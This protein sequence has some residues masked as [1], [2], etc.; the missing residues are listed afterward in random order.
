[1]WNV[2]LNKLPLVQHTIEANQEDGEKQYVVMSQ[3]VRK[4]LID[5]HKV[6]L[7]EG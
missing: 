2:R 3:W 1:M 4:M 6:I 5:K 7:S